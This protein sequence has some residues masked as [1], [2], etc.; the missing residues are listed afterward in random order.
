ML[1]PCEDNCLRNITLDRPSR[2]VSRYDHLPG[3]IEHALLDVIEKEIDLARR[4]DILKRDLETR[5]DYSSLAAYRTIDRYNDG[6]IDTFNLGSFLRSCGHYATERELLS[7][8]RRID[9]DGD[10]KLSYSEFSDYIRSSCPPVQCSL[11]A[12][13]PRP[14]SATRCPPCVTS[15]PLRPSSPPRCHSA[16]NRG[17]AAFTSPERPLRESSP[18]HSPC[19]SP[20]ISPCPPRRCCSPCHS[21]P[22]RCCSLCCLHCPIHKCSTPSGKPVLH[23]HEEDQLV[24][25]LKDWA[26]AERELES[27]KT[28]LALKSDFNIPDAFG[29]FDQR[30][31][32]FIDRYDIKDGCAAIGVFPTMDEIDLFITRYDKTG[33]KRLAQHE[34]AD[35]FLTH[36]TY[37]S[38]TVNRRCSNYKHPIYARDDCFYSDTK[39]AHSSMWRA[40]FRCESQAEGVRQRLQRHP[41]FNVYEAFNSLDLNE[42]GAITMDEIKRMCSSRGFYVSDKEA[43]QVTDKFDKS[44]Y[45]RITYSQVSTRGNRVR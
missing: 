3:D 42:D 24:S 34:F 25:G 15:S 27:S 35:A 8:I 44:K 26:N 10:A 16:S 14:S 45:G 38:S 33:T 7:I 11:G 9:T 29:I 43:C 41:C 12:S 13:E 37:Y 2:Y 28:S 32:G 31:S 40:H 5:Y 18:C 36:D 6:R 23:I 20:C 1:L 19:R 30:K 21:H 17:R 22:C 39:V 4:L